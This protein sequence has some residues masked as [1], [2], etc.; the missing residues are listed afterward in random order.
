MVSILYCR[1]SEDQQIWPYIICK[2]ALGFEFQ[3]RGLGGSSTSPWKNLLL[4]LKTAHL[5]YPVFSPSSIPTLPL[6][7][8]SLHL[9]LVP[10]STLHKSLISFY[11]HSSCI[12]LLFTFTLLCSFLSP[13][14][15]SSFQ[16]SPVSASIILVPVY[17]SIILYSLHVILWC[18]ATSSPF[19]PSP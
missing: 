6:F 2:G 12:I 16:P 10:D 13:P 14:F 7:E 3:T 15:C 1:G 17:L 5:S 8:A 11:Y 18:L 4:E 9:W 19:L